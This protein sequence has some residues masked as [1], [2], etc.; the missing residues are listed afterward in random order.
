M[1]QIPTVV[2]TVVDNGASA[3]IAVPQANVQLKIGCAVGGTPNQPFA[4]TNPQVLQAQFVGGPLVEAGGLVCQAGNVCLAVSAPIVTKGSAYAVQATVPNG[5]TST[6]TVTL[7][8][9]N[10]AWDTYY[11]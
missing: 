10:G 7:D 1:P 8:S 5:S 2:I 9:T 6:V 3:A 11:V 4:T